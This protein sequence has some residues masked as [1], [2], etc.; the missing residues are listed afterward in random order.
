M[1]DKF[2]ACISKFA[3]SYTPKKELFHVFLIERQMSGQQMSR[4]GRA[5]VPK[6]ERHMSEKKGA[7]QQMSEWQ[8]Y[9]SRLL[10]LT[11]DRASYSI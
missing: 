9:Y 2:S 4:V 11:Y 1:H 6:R 5:S 10:K 3:C 7:A 8:V